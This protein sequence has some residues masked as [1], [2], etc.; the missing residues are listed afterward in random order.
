MIKSAGPVF[1]SQTA[2]VIT[3]A[4]VGWGM[5]LFAETHSLYIWTALLLTLAGISMVGP[6]SPHSRLARAEG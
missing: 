5:I 6:R 2:Y 3:L 1:A 4:G